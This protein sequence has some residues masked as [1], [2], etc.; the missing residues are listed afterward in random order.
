MNKDLTFNQKIASALAPLVLENG[1]SGEEDSLKKIFIKVQEAMR[2]GM[3]P[4]GLR[5]VGAVLHMVTQ[6]ESKESSSFFQ[7]MGLFQSKVGK[8][9]LSPNLYPFFIHLCEQYECS[10]KQFIRKKDRICAL[11]EIDPKDISLQTSVVE[12]AIFALVNKGDLSELSFEVKQCFPVWMTPKDKIIFLEKVAFLEGENQRQT[13]SLLK[14]IMPRSRPHTLALGRLFELILQISQKEN[15]ERYVRVIFANERLVQNPMVLYA[16]LEVLR[17]CAL[18]DQNQAVSYFLPQLVKMPLNISSV[19]WEKVAKTLI[20]FPE[21]VSMGELT[22]AFFVRFRES[23]LFIE[24]PEIVAAMIVA[25]ARH[26]TFDKWDHI[27]SVISSLLEAQPRENFQGLKEEFSQV[28]DELS[29]INN[30]KKIIEEKFIELFSDFCKLSLVR[31]PLS[32]QAAMIVAFSKLTF[33][34]RQ[35]VLEGVFALLGNL[36]IDPETI[37]RLGFRLDLSTFTG[38]IRDCFKKIERIE[39]KI[40]MLSAFSKVSELSIKRVVTDFLQIENSAQT[41]TE[42]AKAIASLAR[43]KDI[44]W[45]NYVTARFC[46]FKAISADDRLCMIEHLDRMSSSIKKRTVASQLYENLLEK[47]GFVSFK[48]MDVFSNSSSAD[49]TLFKGS[50]D[51]L[52]SFYPLPG[53]ES[54]KKS[55]IEEMVTLPS[56]SYEMFVELFED[57]IL[58]SMG[59]IEDIGLLADVAKSLSKR[60]YQEDL[61]SYIKRMKTSSIKLNFFK[62]YFEYCEKGWSEIVLMMQKVEAFESLTD[63][64]G[65]IE[66]MVALRE[67]I[68]CKELCKITFPW[69]ENN[70]PPLS[71]DQKILIIIKLF[72]LEEWDRASFVGRIIR[73][74][75][76]FERETLSES[77]DIFFT[78]L[79][80]TSCKQLVFECEEYQKSYQWLTPL[81]KMKVLAASYLLS[82]RPSRSLQDV[83]AYIAGV[84]PSYEEMLPKIARYLNSQHTEEEILKIRNWV[85]HLGIQG[86]NNILNFIFRVFVE[87]IEEDVNRKIYLEDL[88]NTF[89]YE[90]Y[91]QQL[92]PFCNP[93][94]RKNQVPILAPI[95]FRMSQDFIKTIRF[96]TEVPG[97]FLGAAFLEVDRLFEQGVD[98]NRQRNIRLMQGILHLILN[99]QQHLNGAEIQVLQYKISLLEAADEI[100]AFYDLLKER[101]QKSVSAGECIFVLPG[102]LTVAFNPEAFKEIMS[103]KV[104]RYEELPDIDPDILGKVFDGMRLRLQRMGVSDLE[105]YLKQHG[106]IAREAVLSNLQNNIKS[107]N[108]EIYKASHVGVPVEVEE[109]RKAAPARIVK[110]FTILREVMDLSDTVEIMKLED[111]RSREEVLSPREYRVLLIADFLQNCPSGQNEGLFQLDLFLEQF[112]KDKKDRTST[113][114]V[115]FSKSSA[116]DVEDEIV[117]RKQFIES[118]LSD[119]FANQEFIVNDLMSA[120][121]SF[122]RELI[123]ENSFEQI[124]HQSLYLKNLIG[125]SLGLQHTLAFDPYIKWIDSSLRSK[126]KEEVMRVFCKHYGPIFFNKVKEAINE[127]LKKDSIPIYNQINY[128]I[129]EMTEEMWSEDYTQITDEGVAALLK[130]LHILA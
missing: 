94:E 44:G 33:A 115:S 63:P 81:L 101:A 69:S 102:N 106:V 100:Y 10:F 38:N 22:L 109:K 3:S 108:K 111:G 68:P 46:Q 40:K 48:I 110:A 77:R 105:G 113:A 39:E 79:S 25:C 66:K 56:S 32:K 1:S 14:Q 126:S 28:I 95:F 91:M 116:L 84:D 80:R 83:F 112:R 61:K 51:R 121:N 129:K 24:E 8:S 98:R 74:F 7:I 50:V 90:P 15:L 21:G 31:A 36:Y 65:L 37:V 128:F 93:Q 124:V 59:N 125:S 127:A 97:K 52:L 107:P 114:E 57:V 2:N 117:K 35:T 64:L 89:S 119:V 13:I 99:N 45:H 11:L 19:D 86:K 5:Q 118:Y 71:I 17:I 92:W 23:Y 54:E 49:I 53:Y 85:A 16:G 103:S 73:I 27:L 87:G 70:F 18:Y 72:D 58:G 62:G 41:F 29:K 88:K 4:E 9:G 42:P 55:V 12:S 104:V 130:G 47:H 120:V 43:V 78:V 6:E 20:D 60:R 82:S 76:K 122:T 67:K 96:D 75:A 34:S 30:I 123:S 26:A